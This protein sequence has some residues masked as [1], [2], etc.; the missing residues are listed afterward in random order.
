MKEALLA[1]LSCPECQF[2]VELSIL[3]VNGKEI[4]EGLLHCAATQHVYPIVRSV[5]RIL[6]FAF[7]QEPAFTE[8]YT[9]AI[10]AH[11]RDPPLLRA[12]NPTGQKRDSDANGILT[13]CNVRRQHLAQSIEDRYSY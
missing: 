13:E 2:S 1:Y 12:T 6:A 9:R 4:T 10:S 5:P 11:S 8:K 3:G 7:E